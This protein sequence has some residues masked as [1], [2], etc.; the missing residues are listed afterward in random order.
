MEYIARFSPQNFKCDTLELV[1]QT[2]DEIFYDDDHIQY[3]KMEKVIYGMS[4]IKP[5]PRTCYKN[6]EE[7]SEQEY[8]EA[9]KD[10]IH[11]L[12]RNNLHF[13]E[14]GRVCNFYFYHMQD[15]SIKPVIEVEFFSLAEKNNFIR[16]YWFGKEVDEKKYSDLAIWTEIM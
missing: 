10:N 1:E 3:K 4:N 2:F 14:S 6:N 7:I 13:L 11:C 9:K 8:E 12:T 16:P 15:D 5:F